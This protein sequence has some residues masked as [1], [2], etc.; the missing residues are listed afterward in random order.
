MSNLINRKTKVRDKEFANLVTSAYKRGTSSRDITVNE[1]V[2][3]IKVELTKII[4]R[5]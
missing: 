3:E 2:E 5:T 4:H 1:L